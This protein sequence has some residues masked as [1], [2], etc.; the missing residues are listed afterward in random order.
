MNMGGMRQGENG[1]VANVFA[2]N[3]DPAAV[4]KVKA[5]M[6]SGERVELVYRQWAIRPLDIE[7]GHVVIAVNPAK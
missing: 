6:L 4:D 1:A 7:N 3:V 2:F 5:A